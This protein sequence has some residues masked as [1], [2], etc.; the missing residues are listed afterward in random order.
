M[1]RPIQT[2]SALAAA[3]WLFPLLAAVAPAVPLPESTFKQDRFAVG[4]FWAEFPG[5]ADL[6]ARFR[7]IADASFTLVFGPIEGCSPERLVELC[8]KH[9]L[10]A[11]VHA[12]SGS[13]ENLPAGE[14]CWG[15]RVFDEPSKTMFSKLRERAGTIRRIRPGK[16]DYINLFPNYASEK[17]LGVGDLRPQRASGEAYAE[18]VARFVKE[19]DPAVLCFDNYP[20][21]KPDGGDKSDRTRASQDLYCQN[22]KT[23]RRYAL[24][25][26]I[27][28]WNY[29][30]TAPYGPHTDP[31]E[32][33]LRWQI[34]TSL[35]YG[36]R[37]VL[38]FTYGTPDTFEFP[39]GGG[40]LHRDGRRTRHWEQARR[41]NRDVKNLGATLM[42]L[43]STG[44]YR[45][46]PGDNPED[47]LKGTPVRTIRRAKV[48]PPH[49]YLIGIFQHEDGRRAVMV[50][51]YRFAYT[52]WP[53]VEFDTEAGQVFEVD[54]Q[55]G[56][57]IPVADD[58]P[59]MPGLQVSLDS[60]EGRLF[61][62]GKN[63]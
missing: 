19:L 28:F 40:I 23:V 12:G 18:Y 41:I 53:T 33:Q 5:G 60:G 57:E 45:V 32:A 47:V 34:Y 7:E 42:K 26:D 58:S 39:K 62:L 9:G 27:P 3:G 50:N 13:L 54:K 55:T 10:A 20:I 61:M 14:A 37:G 52:A 16:L 24:E 21:F 44:V 11:L 6:D 4:A 35:A 63:P 30:N 25:K 31:T 29:F 46:K 48:D 1:N 15:Y 22:L 17:Q 36:A 56:R 59:K 2:A 38:Y 51:N 43:R 8:Q 49:D